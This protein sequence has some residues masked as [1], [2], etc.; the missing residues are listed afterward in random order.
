MRRRLKF[1]KQVLGCLRRIQN[2]F[3]GCV[4]RSKSW[5]VGDGDEAVKV[6]QEILGLVSCALPID[7]AERHVVIVASSEFAI[8]TTAQ[9]P[10][11]SLS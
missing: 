6:A 10:T 5:L 7:I 1:S 8:G 2:N 3:G 4:T 11:H 9:N